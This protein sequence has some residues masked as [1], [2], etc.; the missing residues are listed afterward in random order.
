MIGDYDIEGRTIMVANWRAKENTIS[1]AIIHAP[2]RVE[3]SM[4]T[5]QGFKQSNM[6]DHRK[7]AENTIVVR[8]S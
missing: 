8:Q 5:L 7:G 3:F 1:S 4:R 2:A 6:L